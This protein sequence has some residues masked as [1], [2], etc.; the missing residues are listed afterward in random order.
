MPGSRSGRGTTDEATINGE[1]R[2]VGQDVVTLRVDGDTRAN[3]YVPLG[4]VTD[5]S[6]ALG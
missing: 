6:V 2:A 3:V 5:I 1:L 4:A